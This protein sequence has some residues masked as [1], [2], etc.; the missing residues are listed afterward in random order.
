M[1]KKNNSSSQE[2]KS[3]RQVLVSKNGPYTVSGRLPLAKEIILVDEEGIPV[4]YGK[5]ERYPRRETYTLC[6]CGQ[7]EKKPHCD[8]THSK[9]HF[10]G[11]ETASRKT[12]LKQADRIKGPDLDLTD[13]V[14][15]CAV[16]RF[17]DRGDGVWELIRHSSDLRSKR[18][19][20]KEACL[21]PAGRLV[22]WNKKT[23]KPIEPR[24]DP[25]VSLIEDPEQG[26]SGPIWVKG[27]IPIVSS[28]GVEYETRNRVTLC[29]CGM[30]ENKPF[31]DGRHIDAGFTDG[32]ESLG[33]KNW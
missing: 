23:G 6:R 17:C 19:A 4:Q 10:D 27:G 31:C 21:C 5:G 12:Y 24:L 3:K 22:A 9:I 29:R 13:A 8:G 2:K 16:A 30:S 20:V 18:L 14:D 33:V 11:T 28:D 32:D 7:S 1:V 26:V 25:S 15:L